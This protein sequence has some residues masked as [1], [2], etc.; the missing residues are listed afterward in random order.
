MFVIETALVLV[1]A[2]KNKAAYYGKRREM[3]IND[4]HHSQHGECR[5]CGRLHSRIFPI[6]NAG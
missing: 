4:G 5:V 3:I 2:A 1:Y 6:E